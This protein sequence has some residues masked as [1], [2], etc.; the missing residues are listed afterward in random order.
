MACFYIAMGAVV[1]VLIA[2][3]I[4]AAYVLLSDDSNDRFRF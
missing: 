3:I 1:T 2:L 4:G